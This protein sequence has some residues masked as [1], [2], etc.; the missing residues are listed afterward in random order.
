MSRI[1]V[2]DDER[3]SAEGLRVLLRADGYDVVALQSALKA[4]DLLATERFD[5]VITD[6]EMPE[7][8]GTEIV[9][10]ARASNPQMPVLVVSAYTGSPAAAVAMKR[11]ACTLIAKPIEYDEL[12]EALQ[13]ALRTTPVA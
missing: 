7:L 9:A 5:A 10:A 3:A 1:L 8:H 2:V 4:R 13:R 6:L 12:A 11:G